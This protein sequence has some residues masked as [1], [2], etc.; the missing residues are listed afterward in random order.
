MKDFS[1]GFNVI[2]TFSSRE[3]NTPGVPEVS[4]FGPLILN[5][6]IN[7]IFLFGNEEF[8]N[9]FRQPS[10]QV[11]IWISENRIIYQALKNVRNLLKSL[12]QI[13]S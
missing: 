2:D 7:D 6:Y 5:I 3:E 13:S 11:A 1:Q 9:A 10:W 8:K 4:I 12:I